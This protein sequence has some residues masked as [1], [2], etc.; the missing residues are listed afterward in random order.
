MYILIYQSAYSYNI[1]L[2]LKQL[3]NKKEYL[4]KR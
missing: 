1:K 3:K 4:Q 2:N